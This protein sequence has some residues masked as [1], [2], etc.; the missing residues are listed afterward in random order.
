MSS[1]LESYDDL[2]NNRK[3]R[4]DKKDKIT[5][6]ILNF[7]NTEHICALKD[8]RKKSEEPGG[9]N[10]SAQEAEGGGSQ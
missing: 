2:H 10:P 1:S 4:A 9:G 3:T 6:D 7:I 8:T 5:G